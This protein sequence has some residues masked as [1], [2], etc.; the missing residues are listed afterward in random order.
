M[1]TPTTLG[2]LIA[3]ARKRKGITQVELGTTLGYEYNIINKWEHAQSK[4]TKQEWALLKELLAPELDVKAARPLVRTGVSQGDVTPGRPAGRP[5]ERGSSPRI[6]PR[7]ALRLRNL[8]ALTGMEAKFMA[9]KLGMVRSQVSRIE[10]GLTTPSYTQLR[11]IKELFNTT[12]DY[13]L[14]GTAPAIPPREL[15]ATPR[16]RQRA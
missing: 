11:K 8:R 4:P 16:S 1:T 9:Q 5:Q 10:A 7:F 3:D 2:S 13:L 12:Y 14:D 6:D 15:A